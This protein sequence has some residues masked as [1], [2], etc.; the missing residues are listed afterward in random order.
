MT[1]RL[2]LSSIKARLY[3]EIPDAKQ[4]EI[5]SQYRRFFEESS[6]RGASEAAICAELGDPELLA[7]EIIS[8]YGQGKGETVTKKSIRLS[9]AVFMISAVMGMW[10]MF[11]LN[12]PILQLFYFT[13]LPTAL[14]FILG[15]WRLFK[16]GGDK[17]GSGRI[18]FGGLIFI[19]LMGVSLFILSSPIQNTGEG[20][21]A[22]LNIP[23]DRIG[24]IINNTSS[25]FLVLTGAGL[26]FLCVRILRGNVLL[27]P[28][29]YM[30]FGVI[31][32]LSS[33]MRLLRDMSEVSTYTSAVNGI[34]LMPVIAAAISFFVYLA[35]VFIRRSRA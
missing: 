27:V 6:T 3:L 11:A 33:H 32:A 5:I 15:G 9:A 24:P 29:I 19:L 34:L 22:L 4:R 13:I 23:I 10:G 18:Y 35:I 7:A 20:I 16:I 28:L 8:E 31:C 17:S 25:V 30:G 26:V 1:K 12:S 14:I 21:Y 2:F